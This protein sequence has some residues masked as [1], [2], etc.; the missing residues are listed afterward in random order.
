MNT[1]WTP[2]DPANWTVPQARYGTDGKLDGYKAVLHGE[3]V[4]YPCLEGRC[5][6]CRHTPSGRRIERSEEA[7]KRLGAVCL[8]DQQGHPTPVTCGETVHVNE[9]RWSSSHRCDKP[10]KVLVEVSVRTR[11]KAPFEALRC[12][13][14]IAM[15]RRRVEKSEAEAVARV[16]RDEANE[17]AK[18]ERA[19]ANEAAVML[20]E[21]C[22][23][24][25]ITLK[26]EA[27]GGGSWGGPEGVYIEIDHEAAGALAR[28]LIERHG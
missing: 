17:R 28:F 26:A 27:H 23:L 1:R 3:R 8:C 21:A 22:D 7:A 20:N 19:A 6:D 11:G 9:G 10:V 12:G 16:E 25:G 5:S 4:C 15:Y 18:Q 2:A 24:L 13:Q 14:H